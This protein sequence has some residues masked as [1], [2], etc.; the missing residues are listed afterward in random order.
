MLVDHIP[1][2]ALSRLTLGNYVFSDAAEVFVFLAGYSAWLAYGQVSDRRGVWVGFRR[3]L[4][5]C[6]RLYATQVTLLLTCFVIASVWCRLAG[7]EPTPLV[8]AGGAGLVRGFVLYAQP[9]F[10]NVLPFYICLLLAFPLTCLGLLRRPRT[11]LSASAGLWLLVNLDPSINLPEWISREGWYFDP[12]A[13]QFLF[14]LGMATAAENIVRQHPIQRSGRTAALCWIVLAGA[15]L[16]VR[17]WWSAEDVQLVGLA[18]LGKTTLHPLRL[19]SGMAVMYLVLT[20]GRFSA[21]ARSD[22]FQAIEV[23][24]KHSL[25]VF[26]AASVISLV[27]RLVFRTVGDGSLPQMAVGGGG[28]FALLAVAGLLERRRQARSAEMA[29][30]RL[31]TT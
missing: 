24:G 1:G 30:L 18:G 23:C 29:G 26:A 10:Y 13:W 3:V 27:G 6:G 11:T 15:W 25:P 5:R 2:S 8:Q 22:R 7:L 9:S 16:T 19:L 12:F 20:S 17:C 4:A 31:A 14:V 28:V 21:L